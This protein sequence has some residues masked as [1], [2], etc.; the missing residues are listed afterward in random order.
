[1]TENKE[2]LAKAEEK[3]IQEFVDGIYCEHGDLMKE[4]E[5]YEEQEKQKQN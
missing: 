2:Q 1:M 4:L 3:E 5:K